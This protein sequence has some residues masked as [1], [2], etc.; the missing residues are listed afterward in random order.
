MSWYKLAAPKNKIR[1]YNI[2]D[3]FLIFFI[4]K[5]ENL[6][7]WREIKD[8]NDIIDHIKDLVLSLENQIERDNDINPYL[9]DIDLERE[10]VN[11]PNDPEVQHAQNIYKRDPETAKKRVLDHLNKAK[12]KSFE[13][14]SDYL[15]SG[16]E[17]Y[18][19]NAPFIYV[20][21]RAVLD[22]SPEDRKAPA[23]SCNP[24]AVASIYEQINSGNK[25]FNIMRTYQ[26]SLNEI[27]S[28]KK[29]VVNEAGDGWLLIPSKYDDPNNFEN[30]VETLK[31]FSIP[32]NWC[33]GSGMAEPY[34]SEGNFW[35][36]IK[37]LR[38]RVAIR[39]SGDR[40][41]EIQGP[42]NVRPFDYWEEIVNFID[43]KGFDKDSSHYRELERA[44]S[45]NNKFETDEEYRNGY[46]DLIKG[47]IDNY[48]YLKKEHQSRPEIRRVYAKKA[49]EI[50]VLSPHF[51]SDPLP[52][53]S[54]VDDFPEDVHAL[55]NFILDD[56][57]SGLHHLGTLT[58]W[59]K[60]LPVKIKSVM[61]E[62]Q[63]RNFA[64]YVQFANEKGG[65]NTPYHPEDLM[66]YFSHEDVVKSWQSWLEYKPERFKNI[67]T[68]APEGIVPLL[69]YSKIKDKVQS[70][71]RN[72]N[73]MPDEMK[74][75]YSVEE[76]KSDMIDWF[77]EAL[78]GKYNELEKYYAECI[79][80]GITDEELLPL[81]EKRLEKFPQEIRRMP[82]AVRKH[83]TDEFLAKAYN[84]K[85]LTNDYNI[86]DIKNMPHDYL[87]MLDPMVFEILREFVR[88]IPEK[89]TAGLDRN[90]NLSVILDS[91]NNQPN[92]LDNNLEPYI[93]AVMEEP[94]KFSDAHPTVKYE[95]KKNRLDDYKDAWVNWS[96][97]NGFGDLLN[98]RDSLKD[99]LPDDEIIYM[100][101]SNNGSIGEYEDPNP[102][103]GYLYEDIGNLVLR[104]ADSSE[105]HGDIGK[106]YDYHK[107]FF[108]SN[109]SVHEYVKKLYKSRYPDWDETE[110]DRKLASSGGN[111][112][113]KHSSNNC[114]KL[115]LSEWKV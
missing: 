76:R 111:W 68:E 106:L 36:F 35:L 28:M 1:Q 43:S 59:W 30:N 56:Y 78:V 91:I 25:Q 103:D 8:K 105:F 74:A 88:N 2:V 33:T 92:L 5:Y 75:M 13:D 57:S 14:W 4:N 66:S 94:I 107:N 62:K 65:S 40:I 72:F 18:A 45:I 15:L 41:E 84:N 70:N 100:I 109:P 7:P 110:L 53:E 63:L 32:N 64:K 58:D 23:L 112:F 21:L 104:Y 49:L 10:F 90:S 114:V 24:M 39:F 82:E 108:V 42:N 50:A 99:I 115:L 61:T 44:V 54:L 48:K 67:S 52:D 27:E 73:A 51:N 20:V 93:D 11:N 6:I 38:A 113:R 77:N 47:D 97:Y 31:N 17:V 85:F 34:L 69:D 96:F 87:F 19:R 81:V 60:D 71:N 101:L 95:I 26:K 37:G 55:L 102:L 9:K 16:N 3:P 29:E 83:V 79:E 12:E 89:E 46:V 22:S 86:Y 80:F 98:S